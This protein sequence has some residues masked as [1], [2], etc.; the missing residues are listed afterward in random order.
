[1]KPSLLSFINVHLLVGPKNAPPDTSWDRGKWIPLTA[2]NEKLEGL[3]TLNDKLASVSENLFD[4]SE[5]FDAPGIARKKS[6]KRTQEIEALLDKLASDLPTT[7]LA[8]AGP[9]AQFN[10]EGGGPTV[11]R[12]GASSGSKASSPSARTRVQTH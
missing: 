7:V 1:L 11:F 2:A 5:R 10:E 12:H 9:G 8:K 6:D 4:I 3:A